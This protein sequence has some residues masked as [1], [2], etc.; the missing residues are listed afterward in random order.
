MNE[1]QWLASDDP[2]PM[3][4]FLRAS[5]RPSEQKLRWFSVACCR[6]IWHLFAD[7]RS[8]KAV[9]VLERLAD[10]GVPR[11]EV[12]HALRGARDAYYELDAEA[13]GGMAEAHWIAAVGACRALVASPAVSAGEARYQAT[14]AAVAA[15]GVALGPATRHAEEAEHC[16]LLRDIFN[17]FRPLPPLPASLLRWNDGIIRQMANAI[18]EHRDLPSGHLRSDR[19]AVLADGLQDAGCED[20]ELL[21]HLRGGGVHVR[22]CWGVDVVLGRP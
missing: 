22:G 12:V 9:E 8:R 15:A 18:Y 5:G 7:E 2:T 1:E 13:S 16:K 6:R 17:P 21:G 19:L 3:L 4:Q 11:E 14:N 20:A 10:G